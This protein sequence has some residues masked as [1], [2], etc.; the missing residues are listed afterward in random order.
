MKWLWLVML[1]LVLTLAGC[2]DEPKPPKDPLAAWQPDLDE[3]IAELE[4]LLLSMADNKPVGSPDGI[5]DG[6]ARCNGACPSEQTLIATKAACAAT[7][8]SA[9][10]L[11]Q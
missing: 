7:L 5:P 9:T 8:G 6:L 10:L 3:P 2:S 1:S 4:N 11:L